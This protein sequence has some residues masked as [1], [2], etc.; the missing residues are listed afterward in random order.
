MG[1]PL[2][3]LLDLLWFLFVIIKELLYELHQSSMAM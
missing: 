2:F 3:I 1:S